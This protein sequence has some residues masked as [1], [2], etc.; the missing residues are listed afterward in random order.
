MMYNLPPF[1]TCKNQCFQKTYVDVQIVLVSQ[2]KIEMI[3]QIF[4]LG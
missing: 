1:S 2:K 3:Y 4:N